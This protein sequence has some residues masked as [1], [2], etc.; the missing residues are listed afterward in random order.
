[1]ADQQPG[2]KKGSNAR[3]KSANGGGATPSLAAEIAPGIPA[4]E[5]EDRTFRPT[6]RRP[7]L[8]AFFKDVPLRNETSPEGP[9]SSFVQRQAGVL[10]CSPAG[11]MQLVVEVRAESFALFRSWIEGAPSYEATDHAEFAGA[12][13]W[14]IRGEKMR[15]VMRRELNLLTRGEGCCEDAP[16]TRCR[17]CRLF[18]AFVGGAPQSANSRLEI[19][20]FWSLQHYR[21]NVVSSRNATGNSFLKSADMVPPG[22]RFLGTIRL[23]DPSLELVADT[24]AALDQACLEGVGARTISSG[25]MRVRLHAILGGSWPALVTPWEVLERID[26]RG[27]DL[28]EAVIANYIRENA[29]RRPALIGDEAR[30]VAATLT[31]L[32]P[33]SP[34]FG[35]EDA[36]G[37]WGA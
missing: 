3:R 1:L 25:K 19:P 35:I 24:L 4:L 13:R 15:G 10:S 23:R 20:G 37:H 29:G 21:A 2:P 36:D 7:S 26:A 18:G 32:S 6:I 31:R 28:A 27:I 34:G 33:L 17:F 11:S 12:L 14:G 9:A 5:C 16:C 30:E 8:P 22:T